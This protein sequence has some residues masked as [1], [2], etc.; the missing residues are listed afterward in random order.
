MSSVR[1]YY[2]HFKECDG[3]I[4]ERCT[5][6]AYVI[7]RKSGVVTVGASYYYKH[8]K[9]KSDHWNRKI[10][11]NIARDRLYSQDEHYTLQF[12]PDF[13]PYCY[14]QYK[15]LETY[16]HILLRRNPKTY[17]I[18]IDDGIKNQILNA[19]ANPSS[20]DRVIEAFCVLCF[21]VCWCF[22]NTLLNTKC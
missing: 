18:A 17:S 22:V 7:D 2:R 8:P 20:N 5:T 4:V 15:V 11:N 9:N 1:V 19:E 16:I 14:E 3:N 6:Y 21:V 12:S 13:D 10:G